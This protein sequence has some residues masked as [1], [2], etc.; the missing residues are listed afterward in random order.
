MAKDYS[1]LFEN[2]FFKQSG[3]RNNYPNEAFLF[4]LRVHNTMTAA[5]S[6]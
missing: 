5:A 2:I 6:F 1:E 3:T 4:L